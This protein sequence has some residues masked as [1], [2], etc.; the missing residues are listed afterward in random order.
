MENINWLRHITLTPSG[1]TSLE[2]VVTCGSSDSNELIIDEDRPATPDSRPGSPNAK[3]SLWALAYEEL[4][5][6]SP[7]L[8]D[9]YENL[10][11]EGCDIAPDADVQERMSIA[12]KSKKTLVLDKPWLIKFMNKDIEVRKQVDRVINVAHMMHTLG[13]TAADA[14]SVHAGLPWA[15]IGAILNVSCIGSLE[16]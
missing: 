2:S 4:R 1:H 10:L 5:D 13:S 7:N 3:R 15:G 11:Q 16:M 14:D 9:D 12:V 8:L 6:T